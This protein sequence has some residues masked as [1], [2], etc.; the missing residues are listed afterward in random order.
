[1]LLSALRLLRR[2]SGGGGVAS[3]GSGREIKGMWRSSKQRRRRLYVGE[4]QSPVPG[5]VG[6]EGWR[7]AGV[8]GVGEG[9]CRKAKGR[10]KEK[11]VGKTTVMVVRG[12]NTPMLHYS[13][14]K[15]YIYREQT[16]FGRGCAGCSVH[17]ISTLDD[18]RKYS[19]GWTA[20]YVMK[21]KYEISQRPSI[22]QSVRPSVPS[23][24]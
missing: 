3:A 11:M 17:D 15:L 13:S 21:S 12:D 22:R 6:R 7:E 18:P 10:E 23:M 16:C 8:G 4:R 1:M 14:Q 5:S 9:P 19:P 24:F 2:W 20:V